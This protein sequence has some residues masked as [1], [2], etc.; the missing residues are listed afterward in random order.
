MET[1]DSEIANFLLDFIPDA[2][3]VIRDE[4]RAASSA[5]LTFP[6]FRIFRKLARQTCTSHELADWM[7]V[8]RPTVSKM[9]DILE[10]RGLIKKGINKADKRHIPLELT[11]KGKTL[12]RSIRGTVQKKIATR[13]ASLKVSEKKSITESMSRLAEVLR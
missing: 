9:I 12:F 8:S 13:M 6:Q 1:S 5:E 4:M 2:M 7:G 10:V 11:D 3:R